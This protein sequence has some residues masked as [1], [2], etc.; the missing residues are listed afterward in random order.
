MLVWE[1]FVENII[2]MEN[3][4]IVAIRF[5]PVSVFLMTLFF[6][7]AGLGS[8][9][10]THDRYTPSLHCFSDDTL[11]CPNIKLI[12]SH[13]NIFIPHPSATSCPSNPAR[14]SSTSH[15]KVLR[16]GHSASAVSRRACGSRRRCRR[17]RGNSAM[18]VVRWT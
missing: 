2:G 11:P 12:I 13:K 9:A 14:C 17:L 3:L 16:P 5:W 4:M 1:G 8:P 10:L 7:V 15:T 6:S 18:V